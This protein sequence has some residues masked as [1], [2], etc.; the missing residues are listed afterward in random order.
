M[1][2]INASTL[3]LAFSRL[4]K[5]K[6]TSLSQLVAI[7]QPM[8]DKFN[9]DCDLM[10]KWIAGTGDSPYPGEPLSVQHFLNIKASKTKITFKDLDDTVRCDIRTFSWHENCDRI[11][12]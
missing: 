12:T 9:D 3:N 8:K 1:K 10:I 5:K 4:F 6:M 11:A 7:T 2:Q